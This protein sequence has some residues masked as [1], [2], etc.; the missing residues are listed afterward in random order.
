GAAE[1]FAAAKGLDPNVQLDADLASDDTRAT[2]A[3]AAGAAPAELPADEPLPE[4]SVPTASTSA[5]A[6][7][8]LPPPAG[9][10]GDM[11]CSPQ[12]APLGLNVPVPMSCSSGANIAEAF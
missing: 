10:P 4:A 7:G 9:V 12:G 3:S 1:A 8:A 6:P 5:V 11:I 2:F